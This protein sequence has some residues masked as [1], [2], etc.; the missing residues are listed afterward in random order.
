MSESGSP[1]KYRLIR[2]VEVPSSDEKRDQAALEKA[3]DEQI[4]AAARAQPLGN[5]RAPPPAI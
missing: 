4:A 3:L 1:A 5:H 2:V